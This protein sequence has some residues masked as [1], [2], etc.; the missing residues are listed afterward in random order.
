MQ[1]FLPSLVQ[2]GGTLEL[3]IRGGGAGSIVKVLRVWLEKIFWD[4]SKILT[5]IIVS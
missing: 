1:H 4:S 5:W 3:K 2:G